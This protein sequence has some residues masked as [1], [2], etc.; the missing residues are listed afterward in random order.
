MYFTLNKL[1]LKKF[2]SPH[3]TSAWSV[4]WPAAYI[5]LHEVDNLFHDP[6]PP[7]PLDPGAK[8]M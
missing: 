7:S 6:I 2:R 4:S 8:L 5:I 1:P 3:E